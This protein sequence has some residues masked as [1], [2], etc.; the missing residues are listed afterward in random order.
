MLG[1]QDERLGLH[2]TDVARPLPLTDPI[3]HARGHT[4]DEL[5]EQI[6]HLKQEIE[7]LRDYGDRVTKELRR[8]Q[9]LGRAMPSE[10]EADDDSPLPPWAMNMPLMSPLLIAY[11][12]RVRDLESLV[13]RRQLELRS[14]GEQTQQLVKENEDLLAE[15]KEKTEALRRYHQD[16]SGI[17][18]SEAAAIEEREELA[19]L[20]KLS[21]E[22]NEV[23]VEQNQLMK[24]QL[25]AAQRAMEELQQRAGTE[26][27]RAEEADKVQKRLTAEAAQ[28]NEQ[29][30]A[31]EQQLAEL[32]AQYTSAL[33][34]RVA[35]DR[36]V[37]ELQAD[38]QHT[39]RL[40]EES[41]RKLE[42]SCHR[43][44][45][46]RQDLTTK[47][48]RLEHREKDLTHAL[49]AMEQDLRTTADKQRQ[50]R[51]EADVLKKEQD[52]LTKSI[53]VLEQKYQETK[54]QLE[55]E[56]TR[57]QEQRRQADQLIL[58]KERAVASEQN[59]KQHADRLERQLTT[60]VQGLRDKHQAE[61]TAK[62]AALQTK[63]NSL[64]ETASTLERALEKRLA[65]IGEEVSSRHASRL[66][67]AL[68]GFW[69]TKQRQFYVAERVLIPAKRLA[70]A[71]LLFDAWRLVT[72]HTKALN[73][74]SRIVGRRLLKHS[75]SRLSEFSD[76]MAARTLAA[77]E[78]LQ[79]IRGR[80]TLNT[81]SRWVHGFTHE[82]TRRQSASC[83][84]DMQLKR[85][86]FASL[87]QALRQGKEQRLRLSQHLGVY[88]SIPLRDLFAR[89]FKCWGSWALVQR[90]LRDKSEALGQRYQR[91][92]TK[93]KRQVRRKNCSAGQQQR[94]PQVQHWVKKAAGAAVATPG[95]GRDDGM[96]RRGGGRPPQP[97]Q[98]VQEGPPTRRLRLDKEAAKRFLTFHLPELRKRDPVAPIDTHTHSTSP[99]SP[100]RAPLPSA[101]PRRPLAFSET[102]ARGN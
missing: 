90:G 42:E 38:V 59:L 65:A 97:D 58:D 78:R 7:D 16:A 14:L 33:D 41:R 101:P 29:R 98:H 102:A 51:R 44:E 32:N 17:G 69:R 80:H 10:T 22:Q 31:A 95:G 79:L 64:E 99:P 26:A 66:M 3:V 1:P 27:Q 45:L 88:A 76:A 100:P 20:Y 86:S 30:K 39:K 70:F 11:D 8:Y 91:Q 12:D 56:Q 73:S 77:S 6:S 35:L 60:E 68:W 54:R 74:I 61:L 96:C 13:E 24:Q 34:D 5:L 2:S 89:T 84:W 92:L 94:R 21:C 36:R 50:A 62:T 85:V 23:L 43:Y 75:H 9:A 53:A 46:E 25:D 4:E 19:E 72:Q 55:Q 57:H 15:C 18:R 37:E 28:L 40:A 71:R 93:T 83:H 67:S 49:S 47:C 63:L 48:E 87:L 81:W 82:Q 52:N